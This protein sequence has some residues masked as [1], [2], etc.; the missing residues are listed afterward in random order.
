MNTILN[1]NVFDAIVIGLI[2]LLSLKGLVSGFTKELLSAV[3]II[4]GIFVATFFKSDI[5][6][7]IS[8]NFIDGVN[9]KILELLSL[10]AIFILV[11]LTAKLI[12]KIITSIL[13]DDYISPASRLAGMLIKLIT[14]FFIFSLIVFSFSS[15]PQVTEKFK[16]TLDRSK[17]YPILKSSGATIL[18]AQ[19]LVNS[20]S[21]N[22]NDNSD[23]NNTI[24]ENNNS[25]NNII[26][27]NSVDTNITKDTTSIESNQTKEVKIST[28]EANVSDIN[29][30]EEK[31]IKESNTTE[32]NSSKK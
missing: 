19:S 23:T 21:A 31:L 22:S 15:K 11:F 4:G 18:N 20:D 7:Y 1:I 29:K 30:S 27:T 24:S 28:N 14:L 25:K 16:D 6:L 17:L 10:V 12:D 5:A 8:K 32:A 9:I 2:L 13:N 3:G 26:N